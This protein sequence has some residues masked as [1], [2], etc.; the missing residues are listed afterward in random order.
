MEKRAEE[1]GGGGV[2]ERAERMVKETRVSV[3]RERRA[4]RSVH[5]GDGG[6]AVGF[7]ADI[8]GTRRD[9]RWGESGLLL[10]GLVTS[11][12]ICL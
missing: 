11:R 12:G 2:R 3:A 6:A 7:V 8:G 1:E 9:G 5:G 4:R 10:L